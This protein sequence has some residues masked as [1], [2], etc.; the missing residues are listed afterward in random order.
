MFCLTVQHVSHKIQLLFKITVRD[1]TEVFVF[2]EQEVESKKGKSGDSC[3]FL[4]EG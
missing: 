4:L 1:E 3:G 2:L